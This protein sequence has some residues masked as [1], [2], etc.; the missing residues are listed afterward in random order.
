MKLPEIMRLP[1]FR[2]TSWGLT[3]LHVRYRIEELVA[4]V[5]WALD[6]SEGRKD[7]A[8]RCEPAVRELVRFFALLWT[9]ENGVPDASCVVVDGLAT[10]GVKAIL[11]YGVSRIIVRSSSDTFSHLLAR[12]YQLRRNSNR[13]AFLHR[14]QSWA[15]HMGDAVHR[16][17][18]PLSIRVPD[19]LIKKSFL[20]PRVVDKSGS[21]S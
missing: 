10:D 16:N 5:Q 13:I 7:W 4:D 3:A 19:G 8:R 12:V 17:L 11:Y 6:A 15:L 21:P 2:H 18:L 9:R 14:T 1:G 20:H